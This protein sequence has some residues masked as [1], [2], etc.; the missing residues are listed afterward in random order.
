VSRAHY[1]EPRVTDAQ[2]DRLWRG[3]SARL[4]A[5]R[6]SARYGLW[7]SGTAVLAVALGA[8]LLLHAAAPQPAA[9]SRQAW[10]AVEVQT[11]ATASSFELTEGSR[12]SLAAHSALFV[13]ENA[14][15]AVS[16]A[17]S[18]GEAQFDVTHREARRFTV[19]AR[20]VQVRVIGTQFVVK[21]GRAPELRVE[22]TVL[23]GVVEV[24]SAQRPG[25]VARVTAGQTWV[26][27]SGPATATE[28]AGGAISPAPKDGSQV[29]EGAGRASNTD[30]KANAS[31]A[32]AGP[33]PPPAPNA[34]E[35]FERASE[36]RRAGDAW[37]A[38]RAYE[39]LLRAH[40]R[41]RRAGLSAF[42]LGRLRMDR[43][44]DASG[45]VA[46][47]ERALS[48]DLGPGFREDALA[49]LVSVFAS[50]GNLS[51]CAS[52]RDRYLKSYPSGVHAVTVAS[53]CAGR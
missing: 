53:R 40:P 41:D 38:A 25:V 1:V 28:A 51:A 31:S 35:L 30:S 39:E 2:L 47:L 24:D 7:W 18:H 42:E 12:V 11:A 23:R 21:A 29:S 32:S 44:R 52:A 6:G 33:T 46:A 22:V 9:R 8:A 3:V 15:N 49:R 16:I 20:D 5:R 48:L 4:A 50:Q 14:S 45:A 17:L 26:Q 43:L 10:A 36:R 34:R 13:Q 37:G 27:S 19:T